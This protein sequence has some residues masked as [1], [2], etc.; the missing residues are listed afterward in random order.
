MS[1]P[2]RSCWLR[3]LGLVGIAAVSQACAAAPSDACGHKS[4]HAEERACYTEL[5]RSSGAELDRVEREIVG[6]VERWDQE[7][8]DQQRTKS[9]LL[10][11]YERFKAFRTAQCEVEASLAAGGNGADDMRLSCVARLNRSRITE[12]RAVGQDLR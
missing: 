3:L 11:S 1:L 2:A 8:G 5:A 12:L 7:A 10:A 6:Q 4:S 9:L